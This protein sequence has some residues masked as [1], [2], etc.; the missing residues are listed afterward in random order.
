MSKKEGFFL[1]LRVAFVLCLALAPIPA[2]ADT[3][4]DNGPIN[5]NTDAWT[6]N[7]GFVVSDT[8]TVGAGGA[9]IT[10][11]DFGAWLYST[12]DVLENAEVSLTSSEFGGTTYFDGVVNFTQSACSINEFGFQICDESGSFNGPSLSGGTYWLNLQNAVVNDGDPVFWDENSGP[13]QASHN[14]V[15]TIPSESFTILGTTTGGTSEHGTVPEPNS[16]LL[17]G[18]TVLG[19]AGFL[20]RKL[21]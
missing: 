5:G 11:L 21:L 4:Y 9:T 15:G 10:G 20:R 14:S 6:I 8:F 16:M 1:K 19:L 13:S 18:S 3:I 7:F 12:G 17:F 2:V